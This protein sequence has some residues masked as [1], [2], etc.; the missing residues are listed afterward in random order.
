MSNAEKTSVKIGSKNR[1]KNNMKTISLL[2]EKKKHY[3][4]KCF[5]MFR[6]NCNKGFIL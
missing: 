5:A 3:K 2:S 1:L 6:Y 4:A